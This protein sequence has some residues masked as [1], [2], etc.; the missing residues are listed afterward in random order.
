MPMT[1]DLGAGAIAN[2]RGRIARPSE[3]DQP[4]GRRRHR[5]GR[6]LLGAGHLRRHVLNRWCA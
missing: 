5:H 3:A 6:L 1:D 4:A 2:K